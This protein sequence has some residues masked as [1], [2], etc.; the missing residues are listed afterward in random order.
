[1]EFYIIGGKLRQRSR[2]HA[3]ACG[4]RLSGAESIDAGAQNGDAGLKTSEKKSEEEYKRLIIKTNTR[5][6]D[7]KTKIEEASPRNPEY[8]IKGILGKK[9]NRLNF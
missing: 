5:I 4:H 9:R 3:K 6:Y 1:L 2:T 7:P 8:W